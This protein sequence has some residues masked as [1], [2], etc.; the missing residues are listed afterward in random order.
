MVTKNVDVFNFFF[1]DLGN[2]KNKAVLKYIGSH[3]C[4]YMLRIKYI[5]IYT[6][7]IVCFLGSIK[8]VYSASNAVYPLSNAIDVLPIN[9]HCLTN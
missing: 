5:Y 1:K 2:E 9:I 3:A 7:R 8:N 4:V 6:R